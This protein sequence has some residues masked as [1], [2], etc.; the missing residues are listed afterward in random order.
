V[1]N[2]PDTWHPL[3]GNEIRSLI[4]KGGMGEVYL[5]MDVNLGNHPATNEDTI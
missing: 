5:A 2:E 4:G 3:A 1:A